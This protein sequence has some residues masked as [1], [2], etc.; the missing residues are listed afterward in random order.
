MFSSNLGGIIS[1]MTVTVINQKIRCYGLRNKNFILNES[2]ISSHNTLIIHQVW[3]LSRKTTTL[4]CR[5]ISILV[6]VSTTMAGKTRQM[7]VSCFRLY[8]PQCLIQCL[9]LGMYNKCSLNY[10]LYV[11]KVIHLVGLFVVDSPPSVDG[12]SLT[13]IGLEMGT[14]DTN[15]PTED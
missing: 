3:Y 2:A 9:S 14:W 11:S 13:I 4:I 7:I 15:L 12:K 1:C 5:V 8:F 6:P 10:F